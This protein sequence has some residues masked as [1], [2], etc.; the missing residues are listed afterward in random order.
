MSEVL[1]W[2]EEIWW[3]RK[4]IPFGS[5]SLS[6]RQLALVVTFGWLGALLSAP[7]PSTLFGMAYLGKALPVLAILAI[8]IV[9]GSQRIRMIP[10]ELQLLIKLSERKHLGLNQEHKRNQEYNQAGQTIE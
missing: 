2:R 5:H 6:P 8:G 7:F 4:S 9:L 1:S 3:E 10:L